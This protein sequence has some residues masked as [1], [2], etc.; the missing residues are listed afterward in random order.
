MPR[1]IFA[2]PFDKGPSLGGTQ[3]AALGA[4]TTS[5]HLGGFDLGD[6][7]KDAAKDI[8]NWVEHAVSD[9]GHFLDEVGGWLVDGPIFHIAAGLVSL[10]PGGAAVGASIEAIYWATKIAVD[11]AREARDV[12]EPIVK[13]ANKAVQAAADTAGVILKDITPEKA[14]EALKGLEA[15]AA[16]G[17]TTAI[18]AVISARFNVQTMAMVKQFPDLIDKKG[19]AVFASDKRLPESFRAMAAV[20]SIIPTMRTMRFGG[21]VAQGYLAGSLDL[22]NEPQTNPLSGYYF[23]NKQERLFLQTVI[24]SLG[25]PSKL[26]PSPGVTSFGGIVTASAESF[27]G[28]ARAQAAEKIAIMKTLPDAVKIGSTLTP[29][30]ALR[31]AYPKLVP[32]TI[33]DTPPP[34]GPEKTNWYQW[35][36]GFW[37]RTGGAAGFRRA[38]DEFYPMSATSKKYFPTEWEVARRWFLQDPFR[39]TLTLYIVKK[40]AF[41]ADVG[42]L[43]SFAKTQDLWSA[44]YAKQL[45]E[46]LRTQWLSRTLEKQVTMVAALIAGPRTTDHARTFLIALYKG[47]WWTI[48]AS[49][50]PSISQRTA[51]MLAEMKTAAAK[52]EAEQLAIAQAAAIV[53][54]SAISN[55]V[56]ASSSPRVRAGILVHFGQL[57]VEEGQFELVDLEGLSLVVSPDGT[58]D[59]GTWRAV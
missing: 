38:V 53:K 12:I 3:H 1:D 54:A 4:I 33:V 42:A 59:L 50:L 5:L 11:A 6:W 13:E 19:A 22:K 25:L 26:A 36:Q 34:Y 51:A 58:A 37:F 44:D 45:G 49:K 55:V 28:L 30:A 15:L 2:T 46:S 17:D 32:V 40:Q 18:G 8:G 20:A 56:A 9:V 35:L 47:S 27:A 39:P 57:T 43:S 29:G 21:A 14:L 52:Y 16:K 10:L 23:Q 31:E 41:P 48:A 7:F 24:T